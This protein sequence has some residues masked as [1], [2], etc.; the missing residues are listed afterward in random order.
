MSL[1]F[2]IAAPFWKDYQIEA[3]SKLEKKLDKL[4]LNYY[5]PRH[6]GIILKDLSPEDREKAAKDVFYTN[7]KNAHPNVSSAMIALIDDNDSGTMYEIGYHTA[8]YLSPEFNKTSPYYDNLLVTF[9]S[10][11]YGANVMISQ[12]SRAHFTSVDD[13]L[14][15]LEK[16]VKNN[17]IGIASYDEY[18]NTVKTKLRTDT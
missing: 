18:L 6:S 3:L 1:K 10:K 9:S 11:G 15:F 13:L 14:K 2:Y 5:S 16:Y 7:V 8:G 17:T 4:G 12:A